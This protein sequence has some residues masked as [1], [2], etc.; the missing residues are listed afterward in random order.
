MLLKRQ[1]KQMGEKKG[2][3]PRQTLDTN[4]SICY[5][6]LRRSALLNETKQ[7]P[8]KEEIMTTLLQLLLVVVVIVLAGGIVVLTWRCSTATITTPTT[9]TIFT[10]KA[11][12]PEEW[13][14]E[15]WRVV[16][17]RPLAEGDVTVTFAN[18]EM[19]ING[20]KVIEYL[21]P[22]QEQSGWIGG[23]ELYTELIPFPNLPDF[24]LDLLIC[25]QVEEE[26][27]KFLERFSDRYLFFW[28]TVY[29]A[30]DGD[31]CVRCLFRGGG[32]WYW[33]NRWLDNVWNRDRP[34]LVL[35]H[36]LDA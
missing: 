20:V 32:R 29:Q 4:P 18:G 6:N 12:M 8:R 16:E 21:S 14:K 17:H 27:A 23:D 3:H 15:K 2:L 1:V 25:Q 33:S 10:T 11:S 22:G 13:R 5:S 26:V 7:N 30:P 31:R 35:A 36:H 24:L 19:Y 9:F 28:G 34:A